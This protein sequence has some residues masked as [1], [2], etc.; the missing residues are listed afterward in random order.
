M[1]QVIVCLKCQAK[2]AMIDPKRYCMS[3]AISYKEL[4]KKLQEPQVLPEQK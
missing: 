2:E 4:L 1:G 3:C